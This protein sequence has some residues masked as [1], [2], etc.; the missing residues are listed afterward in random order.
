MTFFADPTVQKYLFCFFFVFWNDDTSKQIAIGNIS[1]VWAGAYLLKAFYPY[2]I[3]NVHKHKQNSAMTFCWWIWHRHE[4]EF[5]DVHVKHFFFCI[6]AVFF[7]LSC[8]VFHFILCYCCAYIFFRWI[9]DIWKINKHT[10]K[11]LTHLTNLFKNICHL[12]MAEMLLSLF[13]SSKKKHRQTDK[14]WKW[15]PVCISVWW[16]FYIYEI[17][18]GEYIFYRAILFQ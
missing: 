8:C 18:Q 11:L 16:I 13:I 14:A 3:H 10:R 5:C 15:Y 17:V 1:S 2:C 6:F 7:F 12:R 9:W 4:C